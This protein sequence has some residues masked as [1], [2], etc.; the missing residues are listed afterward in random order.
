MY[1]IYLLIVFIN[2][3]FKKIKG[4]ERNGKSSSGKRTRHMNIRYFYIM[5]KVN[6]G[7]VTLEYCPTEKMV[8]DYF[9][10]PLQGK[11]FNEFIK[12]IMNIQE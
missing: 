4:K 7:D 3:L 1:T 11:R 12:I 10:K 2:L 5:D 8:A 9:T 6:N